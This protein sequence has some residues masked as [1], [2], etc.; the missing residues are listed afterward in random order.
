MKTCIF[1]RNF[2]RTRAP[3]LQILAASAHHTAIWQ[4]LHEPK[5]AVGQH[6]TQ[7]RYF[8]V[9]YKKCKENPSCVH[10]FLGKAMDFH[11]YL[12]WTIREL[13]Q[14]MFPIH[15]RYGPGFRLQFQRPTTNGAPLPDPEIETQRSLLLGISFS[16][17]FK[18]DRVQPLRTTDQIHMSVAEMCR[19]KLFVDGF[20]RHL[21]VRALGLPRLQMHNGFL[22]WN[23]HA[24]TIY[25][26]FLRFAP[27]MTQ[28]IK[29][30]FPTRSPIFWSVHHFGTCVT[31][32]PKSKF[33]SDSK[34][35][36]PHHTEYA[37]V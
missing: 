23:H 11:S 10:D 18:I 34:Q 35:T 3:K 15:L 27:K 16:N 37:K 1:K 22:T 25:F 21:F 24:G 33:Q 31:F 8:L 28:K 9:T 17:I 2:T 12:S 20:S 14:H 30:V 5:A 6:K 19:R 29:H 36:C 7:N 13:F 26:H 4:A 32:S